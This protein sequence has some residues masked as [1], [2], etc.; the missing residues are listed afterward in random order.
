MH[1][2]A[3]LACFRRAQGNANANVKRMQNVAHL[4]VYIY[5]DH[6][7]RPRQVYGSLLSFIFAMTS[8]NQS[9]WVYIKSKR[10]KQI[11]MYLFN[12]NRCRL[13]CYSIFRLH[14]R[15]SRKVYLY[16]IKY[17]VFYLKLIVNLCFYFTQIPPCC[18]AVNTLRHV[19]WHVCDIV[20]NPYIYMVSLSHCTSSWSVGHDRQT[21]SFGQVTSKL[22][23]KTGETIEKVPS[24]NHI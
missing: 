19:W 24:H 20:F 16:L 15:N 12:L 2:T 11:K 1:M 3:R 6:R 10:L 4:N 17:I 8:I 21:G 14:C 5:N 23:Q 9:I 18:T 22:I 7:W 13:A